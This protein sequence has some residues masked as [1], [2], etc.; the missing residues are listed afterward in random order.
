MPGR[1]QK[2]DQGQAQGQGGG[3]GG[4]RGRGRG[5]GQAQG[6]GRGRGRGS[7]P[8]AAA[9]AAHPTPPPPAPIRPPPPARAAPSVAET[10]LE[11]EEKAQISSPSPQLV[12]PLVTMQFP[13]RPGFGTN[14]KKV[15]LYA[16]HFKV[17]FNLAGDI[18][19]YD[20][21]MAENGSSFGNDGPP[22]TLAGKIM[23][24]LM[25]EL[26]RQFPQ[27]HVVSDS[28]KNIYSPARLPFQIQEF[29]GL[30][31]PDDG[32]RAREFS[33]VVKEA[34]P[35]AIRMQQLEELFAGRLNYTPYDAL[36]ALD[37]VGGRS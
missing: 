6:Q 36:Q 35:V 18:Y 28:R 20:V 19:H 3:R 5:R 24:A 16:N 2:Q 22:K 29:T 13:P 31:L 34:D 1:R 17:K 23:T 14:G 15:K 8:P 27:F 4:G 12:Q 11:L 30:Q 7:A 21:S 37:D 10:A 32:G 25:Q 33:A 9:P 26:K